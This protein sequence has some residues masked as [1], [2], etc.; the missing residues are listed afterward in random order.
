MA[1]HRQAVQAPL[2][3][4]LALVVWATAEM[5]LLRPPEAAVTSM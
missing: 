1:H 3:P 2:P 5:Q 4:A